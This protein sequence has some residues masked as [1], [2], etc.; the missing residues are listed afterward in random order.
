[1]LP[2]LH[3]PE[4]SLLGLLVFFAGIVDSLAGGGGLIT[5]P[6]YLS[7]GLSPDLILGTNK[8]SSSIGTVA[9]SY[10]YQRRKKVPWEEISPALLASCGGSFLGARL[11]AFMDPRWLKF[12]LLAAMPPMLYFLYF[13]PHFGHHDES[14]ALPKK[15][16]R[17]ILLLIAASLGAYDGFFGPGTGT[18]LALA[19]SRFCRYDLLG[20]TARAKILNLASNLSALAAFLWAGKA[21]IALGLSMGVLSLAGHWTGSHWGFKKGAS[22]IRPALLWVCGGLFLKLLLA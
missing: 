10:Q 16:R 4:F 21:H 11:A 6:A 12:L 22:V 2:A 7:A 19:L 1:M 15:E 5:L 18:F 8:L 3:W 20:S 9:S 14:E 13:K 17:R